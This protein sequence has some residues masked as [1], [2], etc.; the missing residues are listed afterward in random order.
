MADS[1][2]KTLIFKIK[3]SQALFEILREYF[4][5]LKKDKF[6][7]GNP[8]VQCIDDTNDY[9]KG[10]DPFYQWFIE[11]F[12]YTKERVK[13]IKI[14]DIYKNYFLVSSYYSNLSKRDKNNYTEK[15]FIQIIKNN[16][17]IGPYLKDRYDFNGEHYD[18]K[19]IINHI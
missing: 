19:I 18:C 11:N 10:S 16:V 14:K 9:L 12:T 4:Q 8:P 15:E 1:N 3:Y 6:Y 7:I 17:F 5:L 2:C 13:P